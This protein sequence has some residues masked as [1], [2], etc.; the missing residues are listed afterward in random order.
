M[1]ST[2]DIRGAKEMVRDLQKMRQKAVPYAIRNYLNTAAFETRRIWQAEIKTT[3]INRN[4][5][6]ANSVRVDQA[7]GTD[8]ATMQAVV[9]SVAPWLKTDEE[10]GVVHSKAG[11][12]VAIPRS[13]SAGQGAGGI[14][15]KAVRGRF[16]LG[17]INLA[18][19]VGHGGRRQQNAIAIA[20][21]RKTGKNLA[22]LTKR[23]GGK[24]IFVIG[25]GK[26]SIRTRMLYDVSRSSVKVRSEP[27]LQRSL[28]AV[29]PKLESMLKAAV[30]QQFARM[31]LPTK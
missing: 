17:A 12:H 15:T 24:G 6:T 9:G 22:L 7:K 31:N 18:H 2:V 8:V 26:R 29:K 21:A 27:T 30:M 20:I 25:G 23:N 28:D 16:Y 13:A 11:S 14:R 1:P 19:P 4:T 3:F 10:G 5:F